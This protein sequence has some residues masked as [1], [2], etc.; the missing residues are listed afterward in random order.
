MTG[1][2]QMA[3]T[4]SDDE[5][6]LIQK[7]IYQQAG[8]HIK[9][10]KRA[11]VTNRLRKRLDSFG[12]SSYL[13]YYN[14]V[15]R[16]PGGGK[17]LA[18]FINCLT[19][20][21]TYFFRHSEQF[22]FLI[23]VLLPE[24]RQ[25]KNRASDRIRIW[26]AACSSGEEPYSIAMLVDENLPAA[27]RRSVEIVGSDINQCM[28]DKAQAGVYGPHS[29]SRTPAAYRQKYF[30]VNEEG[31]QFRLSEAIRKRVN[32]FRHNLIEPFSHGLFDVIFCRNVLIYFD[33][34]SKHK[35]LGNL[36]R[37]LN[38]DGHLIIDYAL[39]LFNNQPFFRFRK[40]TVYQKMS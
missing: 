13:R 5:F 27:Q 32:F 1:F 30:E 10:H 14:F 36:H 16:D 37:S 21:E 25:K 26:C 7:L 34:E 35:A 24:L 33:Q 38:R 19:T 3:S 12:F 4:I 40:P 20:K 6:R 31:D 8:I 9:D 23:E 17:E 2:S 29:M 28:V 18:E 11:M 22:N 15:T 39:S